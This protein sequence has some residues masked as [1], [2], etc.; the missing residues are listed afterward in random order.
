MMA[1]LRLWTTGLT[2]IMALSVS[3]GISEDSGLPVVDAKKQGPAEIVRKE[4]H[5]VL[6]RQKREWIWNSYYVEE[7]KPG[8]H[9][10]RIG[11][12]L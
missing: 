7:E 4:N 9:P 12:V 2:A 10:E 1:W 5:P 6:F 11:K 8:T 3:L